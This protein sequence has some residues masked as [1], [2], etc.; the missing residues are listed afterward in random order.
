MS[1]FS[2]IFKIGQAKMNQVVDSLEKPEAMLD[3]AIRDKEK[4]LLD[5]KKSVASCIA[6]IRQTEAK[7]TQEKKEQEK[8]ESNAEAAV[9]AGNEDLALK[10][11]ARA[12][13]HE[14]HA[15][16]YQTNIDS[17]QEDVDKLK[18]DLAAQ[19]N[20]LA[21]YKRNKDFII[22]QSKFAEAKK[23][24]H[25]ARAKAVGGKNIDNLM[26]RMKQKADKSRHEA[27]AM[28]ELSGVDSSLEKEFENLDGANANA[29]LKAKL[30]EMKTKLGK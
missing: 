15:A 26:E 5:L 4:Q 11:L 10:A 28:E 24:I 21:E 22:A 30:A 19:Q 25:E 20:Q 1:I 12:K 13:E 2:R 8:W 6:S 7:M 9:T 14:E 17:Q 29:E 27:E 3:Q 18:A 16:Q 23:D